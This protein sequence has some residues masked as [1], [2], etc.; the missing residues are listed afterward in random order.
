[1]PTY[2]VDELEAG[3]LLDRAVALALGIP[4][5]SDGDRLDERENGGAPLRWQPSTVWNDGMPLV[6]AHD[7]SLGAP[8]TPVH[9]NGGPSAGMGASGV[10]GATSWRLRGRDGK[11]RA[12][13]DDTEPLAAAMKLLVKCLVGDTVDLDA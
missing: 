3:P 4:L 5:D 2:K 6:K 12:A 7:I 10:W 9:R 11:R 13:W 1:M 8:D